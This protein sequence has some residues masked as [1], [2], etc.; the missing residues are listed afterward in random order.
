VT[1]TCQTGQA[2][3]T[4]AWSSR[5]LPTA[6][7][8]LRDALQEGFAAQ[9]QYENLMSRGISHNTALRHAFAGSQH[10]RQA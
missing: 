4:T 1:T 8:N 3:E 9:R 10:Q 5:P 6:L 7:R 2:A